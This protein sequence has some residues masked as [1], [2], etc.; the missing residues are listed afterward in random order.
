M[1]FFVH[2]KP[3]PA[4]PAGIFSRTGP[5]TLQI[6]HDSVQHSHDSVQQL[7]THVVR[8]RDTVR[9]ARCR[10]KNRRIGPKS[11]ALRRLSKSTG[12]RGGVS[13]HELLLKGQRHLTDNFRCDSRVSNWGAPVPCDT[14]QQPKR[15]KAPTLTLQRLAMRTGR[16]WGTMVFRPGWTKSSKHWS[17]VGRI[18][19]PTV[20]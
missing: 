5:T 12:P 14:T 15:P 8:F 4:G 13:A 11:F 18:F 3:A 10:K 9:L 7:L 19:K 17:S 6:S 20:L 16:H 1:N 2:F